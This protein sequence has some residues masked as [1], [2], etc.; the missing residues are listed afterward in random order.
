VVGNQV[1][2]LAAWAGDQHQ[3]CLI[4]LTCERLHSTRVTLSTC[5]HNGHVPWP[6]ESKQG[7]A[8]QGVSVRQQPADR[9][10]LGSQMQS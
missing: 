3:P 8:Q 9:Q 10:L 4:R 2:G 6:A 5:E 1:H 7:A